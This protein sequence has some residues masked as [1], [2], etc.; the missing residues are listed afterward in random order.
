VP[1]YYLAGSLVDLGKF[2]LQGVATMTF[3]NFV[4]VATLV[5]MATPAV[6]HRLP[7]PVL[8]RAA[9]GQRHLLVCRLGWF[10]IES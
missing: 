10:C 1:T 5:L 6:R 2:A 8:A 9:F 4:V 7:F 3:A